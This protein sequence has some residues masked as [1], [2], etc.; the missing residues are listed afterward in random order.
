MTKNHINLGILLFNSIKMASATSALEQL[1]LDF[2]S[3]KVRDW[4]Y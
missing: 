4:A 1:D 3:S 2:D